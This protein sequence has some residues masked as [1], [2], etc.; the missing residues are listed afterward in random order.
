MYREMC[1]CLPF[2]QV[3]SVSLLP[4]PELPSSWCKN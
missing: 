3:F 1:I 2:N 4:M